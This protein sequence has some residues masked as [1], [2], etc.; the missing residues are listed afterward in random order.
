[1]DL[2][3]KPVNETMY[4]FNWMFNLHKSRYPIRYQL[5]S[6]Y[7]QHK[8]NEMLCN[9]LKGILKYLKY[10]MNMELVFKSE[11]NSNVLHGFVDADWGSN[12]DDID[13]KST[14]V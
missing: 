14:T 9:N 2:N 5:F 1:M 13:R 4:G 10:T 3:S 6:K 8:A 12:V 11:Q 7:S